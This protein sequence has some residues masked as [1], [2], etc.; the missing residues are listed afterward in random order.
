MNKVDIQ[1]LDCLRKTYELLKKPGLLLASADAGGRANTMAIGVGAIDAGVNKPI[2]IVWVRPSRHT[3][4]CI[5]ATG[6]FTVNVPRP[7]M[8]DTVTYCGTVSGRD[9]DKFKEKGLTAAA[10]R[11]VTS[12]IIAECGIHYECR[13][14]HKNDIV[15]GNLDEEFKKGFYPNGD[16][17]RF[18][19]GE[20]VETYADEDIAGSL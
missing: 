20:I 7:G 15:P 13:V 19:F 12:P 10:S 4:K 3:Y 17:H 6:D 1:Y 18:Y 8:E 14:I 16:Y 11:S 2:F 9:H 5:E